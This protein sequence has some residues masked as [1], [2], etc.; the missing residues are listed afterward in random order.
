MEDK[1]I[2]I[3]EGRKED[4][5]QVL[6]LIQELALY[7]K[8]PD[9]VENTL[10]M[11]VEDGFGE[12][13]IYGF[14]VAE[15]EGE[16]VG[17]ALYYYRYST[18]KGKCLYLEDLVV[19]EPYRRYG[20]GK[21]LFNVIVEKAKAVHASRINWQVLEWNELA[22]RFYKSLNASLDSEWVNCSLTKEQID[23]WT[24]V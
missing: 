10:E 17:L 7:E 14:Y 13:P 21:R 23:A 22:I 6:A 5:P 19:T 24:D 8:A 16:V 12:N 2:R 1:H 11:M 9:E 18:W 3:R 4:L 20:I 15:K